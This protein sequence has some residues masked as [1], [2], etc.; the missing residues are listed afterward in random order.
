MTGLELTIERS[1]QTHSHNIHFK[2]TGLVRRFP[3]RG[4]LSR[5]HYCYI[6]HSTE[7]ELS[8]LLCNHSEFTSVTQWTPSLCT[9]GL[10]VHRQFLDFLKLMSIESVMPSHRLIICHPASS[11]P[12]FKLSQ[13]QFFF[14]WVSSFHQVAKVLA[15]QLQ[16]ESFQWTLRTDLL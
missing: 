1:N 15:F 3:R 11:P 2:I 14:Q 4:N 16:H 12:A 8:C 7:L 10:P 5:I 6:I 13:H 9:P